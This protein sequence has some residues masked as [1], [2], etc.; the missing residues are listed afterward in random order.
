MRSTW[1]YCTVCLSHTGYH[2]HFIFSLLQEQIKQLEEEKLNLE[3]CLEDQHQET[4]SLQTRLATT[5]EAFEELKQENSSLQHQIDEK[6]R[7][8]VSST[9]FRPT[10][11]SLQE[12]LANSDIANGMS[13][14][15]MMNSSMEELL[16]SI[17][18]S[19]QEED[20][21]LFDKLASSVST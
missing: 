18:S 5:S 15:V 3:A 12:E 8:P 7:V 9:P 19:E 17:K 16:D 4:E 13:P 2:P 21:D 11:P 10:A 14:M 6:Q 1:L 20:G